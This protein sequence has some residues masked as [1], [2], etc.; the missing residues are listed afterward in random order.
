[1][2]PL[3]NY[4]FFST[5]IKG[6]KSKKYILL[7]GLIESKDVNTLK[8]LLDKKDEIEF[9][10]KFAGDTLLHH[11]CY[12][13]YIEMVRLLLNY[14]VV[15]INEL[16]YVLRTPLHTAIKFGHTNITDYLISKGADT[17]IRDIKSTIPLRSAIER[18]SGK[19]I[20]LLVKK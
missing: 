14:N 4:E 9:I 15:D 17:S 7:K 5:Y 18:R 6:N 16:D 11:A 13:G 20:E 1:M 19:I 3:I 2:K 12:V 8:F 10:P